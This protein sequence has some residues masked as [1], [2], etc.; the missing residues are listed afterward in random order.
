MVNQFRVGVEL[1]RFNISEEDKA[2][3][4]LDG[5]KPGQIKVLLEVLLEHLLV[6]TSRS[7]N[8]KLTVAKTKTAAAMQK[9]S[10]LGFLE[11]FVSRLSIFRIPTQITNYL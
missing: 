4:I 10:V 6:P 5:W 8:F 1:A 3:M 2:N 11:K 9:P 7:I